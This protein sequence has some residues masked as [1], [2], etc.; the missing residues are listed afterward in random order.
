MSQS[1]WSANTW[2]TA[3]KYVAIRITVH[4]DQASRETGHADRGV[5]SASRTRRIP[6]RCHTTRAHNAAELAKYARPG[7]A[8]G[9]IQRRAFT[10][11]P[12]TDA[13]V[14]S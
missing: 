1:V 4:H 12:L 14:A 10:H 5:P 3:A 2:I 9:A 11:V 13:P 6:S 7:S 8:S